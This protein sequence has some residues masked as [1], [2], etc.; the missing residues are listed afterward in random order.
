MR[1]LNKRLKGDNLLNAM[2]LIEEL[3]SVGAEI[4][5]YGCVTLYHRT[6]DNS[7]IKILMTGMMIA[8]ED[9]IFFSTK[10]TGYND[11]YGGT[12]L[13]FSIP[14]EKLTLDYIFEN[15]A[16]VKIELGNARCLDV[17]GYL[18]GSHVAEKE[19]EYEVEL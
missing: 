3:Q 13:A 10:E 19:A 14:I 17:A 2:D 9:G 15:E 8:R 7:A 6:D 18:L 5:E 12:V 16:H 4:D 1:P 11:G